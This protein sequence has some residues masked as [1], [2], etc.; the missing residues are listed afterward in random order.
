[1]RT[2]YVGRSSSPTLASPRS[3][4]PWRTSARI[5]SLKDGDAN[6]SFHR[7]CTYPKQKNMI[8]TL[9]V[10]G[11]TLTDQADLAAAAFAHSLLG[12]DHPRDCTLNL[13]D[14]IAPS[15]LDDLDA[16]FSED[17]IWQ[18]VERL[19]ARKA[20]GPDGFTAE[21]LRSCWPIVKHDLVRVFQQLYALR[22][23]GSAA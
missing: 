23:R 9:V 20:P 7:R 5:A 13:E 15:N 14:L 10:E 11:A 8:H 3:N 22:V 18:A 17:E 21:F 19:P 4:E 12:T 1:M 6:T 16:P 2:G